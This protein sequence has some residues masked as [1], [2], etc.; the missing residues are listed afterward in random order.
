MDLNISVSCSSNGLIKIIK[1][2][3]IQPGN[4]QQN[5]YIERYHRTVRYDRLSQ[6]LFESIA[7]VQLHATEWLWTYN[8]DYLNSAILNTQSGIS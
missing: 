2:I 4:P 3:F 1:L 5:A 7:E 6:Y 8:S